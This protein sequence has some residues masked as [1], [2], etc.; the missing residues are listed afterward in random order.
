MGS[1]RENIRNAECIA[2]TRRTHMQ[3]AKEPS[4]EEEDRNVAKRG[5]EAER[6]RWPLSPSPS[7]S[8]SLQR[9]AT[10]CAKN[11]ATVMFR[12]FWGSFES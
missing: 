5:G 10:T 2:S 1:A 11:S 9:R 6:E 7:L 4:R 3:E 8:P 12:T